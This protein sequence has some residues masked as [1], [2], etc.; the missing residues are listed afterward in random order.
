MLT[1]KCPSSK[2]CLFHG[3]W[4]F[5]DAINEKREKKKN[6]D[7]HCYFPLSRINYRYHYL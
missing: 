6:C 1:F 2:Y 5:Q 4:L 7:L 3:S